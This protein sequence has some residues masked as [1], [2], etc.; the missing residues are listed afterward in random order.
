M[1]KYQ[2][3]DFLPPIKLG[4]KD[5]VL[6]ALKLIEGRQWMIV[7]VVDDQEH[8]LGVASPG[9]LR[10]AIL[11]GYPSSTPLSK[12]MNSDPV[13]IKEDRLAQEDINQMFNSL[14]PIYGETSVS[15]AMIPVI[16]ANQQIL[17]LM[18]SESLTTYVEDKRIKTNYR[19]VLVVGG[20]GYIG[21]ILTRILLEH[22]W[23]VRV[24]DKFLYADDSL[25]GIT[26]EKFELIE[27]DAAN[28]DD[29]VKAVDGVDAVVYLAELVGDPACAKAPQAALKTN[30]LA[31]TSMAHLCSH[32][33]INRFVYMSS[34]SVYGASKNPKEFLTEDSTLNPVSLYARIK[35]LV[36]EA[37]LSVCN[38]PNP[39]FAP[40][41]LRLGTVF[42]PSF[43]PR[44]DL[45]VNIFAKNAYQNKCIEV[46]GGDQW[47]PNVH[48]R[49]V[50]RAVLAVLEA[51]IDEV[52][53]KI[54]N[55]GG[56][57]QNHTINELAEVTQRVFSGTKI[58]KNDNVVDQRNY[59]VSFNKIEKAI[60]FRAKYSVEDA[61]QDFRKVFETNG[62][63]N[64]DSSKF[65]NVQT[66]QELKYI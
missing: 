6:D 26:S 41:I 12:V 37:I 64:L 45:V 63:N 28:I 13:C 55:V 51:P 10:R 23:S 25:N 52:R 18:S 57:A 39:L 27:G 20:A 8:L 46:H 60:G 19:T 59:R 36:E 35:S 7:T 17:G 30:Y 31:V 4:G 24:L 1:N 21:S 14:R 16:N 53:A 15:Y 62:I 40:T 32:L 49:D 54:F 48:V 42:G 61:L 66:L 22:G 47:R 58:V 2:K 3:L 65:N 38:L 29:I 44:F 9:D 33:N 56:D 43:R 11:Q 5:T 50:A 34:C